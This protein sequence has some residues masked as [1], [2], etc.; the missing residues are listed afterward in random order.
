MTRILGRQR[1]GKGGS[2]LSQVDT[3]GSLVKSTNDTFPIIISIISGAISLR[4]QRFGIG[5][6]LAMTVME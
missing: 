6:S 2:T 5:V 1:G 3:A 4:K